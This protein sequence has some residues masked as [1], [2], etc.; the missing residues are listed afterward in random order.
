M[1]N[2]PIVLLAT[3]IAGG[4]LGALLVLGVRYLVR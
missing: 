4:L 3:A 2:H 1:R